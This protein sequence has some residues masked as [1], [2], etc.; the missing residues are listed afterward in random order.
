[1]AMDNSKRPLTMKS[2]MY[3]GKHSLLPPK[4][5]FPSIAP[6]YADYVSNPAIGPKGPPKNREGSPHHQ[7]TSSESFLIEEQPSWL[8]DLLNEPETPVKRG[9]RRSSSDSFTYM[10][11]ANAAY[12]EYQ[13]QTENRLRNLTSVPS[14][15]S[16]DFDL[17]KD[18]RNPSFYGDTNAMIKNKNRAWDSPQNASKHN[19]VLQT[20]KSLGSS[21]EVDG[22]TSNATEKKEA[23][24]SARQDA[25]TSER[26]DPSS[27]KG[28]TSETD[29]KRAKQQFA[30]RSRVRK[31]QYIAELEKNVHAL[32]A[33]GSEVAAEVEFLNQQ[34]LILGMENKALKQRLDNLAQ[35]QLIKYMEHEVLER[36]IGRLRALY[37]QQLQPP[38]PPNHRRTTSKDKLD[39]QFANLSLKKDSG[40]TSDVS[41]TLQI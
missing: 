2:M 38:P 34:S 31:L 7:R 20:S 9:H 16:Q 5:P 29:T 27:N 11:A 3:N 14:W 30:Q 22:N 18:F 15:G 24:E 40:S 26:K 8:D 32:Q 37:Q 10:E 13:A 4:S 1:M 23:V 39:A 12:N 21:R 36:E 35:E 6:S 33:E 25:D 17:Y 28:S 19:F 41:G